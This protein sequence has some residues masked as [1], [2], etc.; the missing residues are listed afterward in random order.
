MQQITEKVNISKVYLLLSSNVHVDSFNIESGH[1][2]FN[3]SF[4]IDENS[5]KILDMLESES[6]VLE[7]TKMVLVYGQL[8]RAY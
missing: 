4:L 8:Y 5:A 2:C 3:Y 6:S 7:D 1:S